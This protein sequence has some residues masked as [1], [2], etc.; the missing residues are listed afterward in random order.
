MRTNVTYSIPK[1]LDEAVKKVADL[2]NRKQSGVVEGKRGSVWHY[3]QVYQLAK[4]IKCLFV[5]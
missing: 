4:T 3:E 2:T 5:F 1:E